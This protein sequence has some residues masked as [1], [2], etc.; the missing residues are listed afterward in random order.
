MAVKD[1]IV[2][3]EKK[4]WESAGNQPFY[5]QNFARDGVMAFPI[6]LMTKGDV[7]QAMKG[8]DEWESYTLDDLRFVQIT[9]DVAALAYTTTAVSTGEPEPYA[10]AVISVYVRRKE[11]WLLI[12]H[13]QTALDQQP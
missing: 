10:A 6:G 11:G 12:L 3:L 8:A 9:D 2:A 7:V 13:Q 5:E 4:F 1:E